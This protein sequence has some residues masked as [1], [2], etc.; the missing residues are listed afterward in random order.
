MKEKDM[1]QVFESPKIEKKNR[2]YRYCVLY[3]NVIKQA[4]VRSVLK[5]ALP[6]GRGTVF[7]PCM[8]CYRRD[9]GGKI[10]IRPIFPGY[11]FIRSD[12]GNVELHEF[13]RK[14][15]GGIMA[16][17]R[18]LKLSQRKALGEN[19]LVG[20]D[21]NKEEDA[22]SVRDTSEDA[23]SGIDKDGV[24][25]IGYEL[26]DLTEKEAEFLDFLLDADNMGGRKSGS[27]V[28]EDGDKSMPTEG[29]LKMSYG[30]QEGNRYKVMKGPLRAFETH[31]TG[32]NKHDKKAFLDFEINGRVVRAGFDVMPKHCWFPEDKD[33]PGV[34]ADGTEVDLQALAKSMMG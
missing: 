23:F 19:I 33:A 9:A 14:N 31:I 26:S 30:Y 22:F 21:E 11:I 24:G 10:E 29:L 17:V 18:E 1:E 20:K 32:V 27:T 15:S 3:T 8:E 12:M 16:F 13:V 5:K 28:E 2:K 25:D 4:E 34:L 7:Y 6:E